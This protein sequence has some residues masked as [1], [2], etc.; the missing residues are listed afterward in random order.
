MQYGDGK[1][2]DTAKVYMLIMK[3]VQSKGTA[4]VKSEI[5]RVELLVAGKL[6]LAKRVELQLRL[7]ILKS[8]MYA[9]DNVAG[10]EEA[11]GAS[12][13]LDEL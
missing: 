9:V 2:R 6:P 11:S 10:R 4:F 1:H 12:R 13:N 8:I 5:G 7:D 3:R